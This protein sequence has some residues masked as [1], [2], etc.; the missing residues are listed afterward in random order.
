MVDDAGNEDAPPPSQTQRDP[1]PPPR[2]SL[3]PWLALLAPCC[4][5]GLS[6]FFM[7]RANA[8]RGPTGSPKPVDP[9]LSVQR[10]SARGA[11][12]AASTAPLA[13]GELT[14]P[15]FDEEGNGEQPRPGKRVVPQHFATVQQAAVG[16][17]STHSVDGLSRQIIAQARC[18]EPKAFVPLP[19]RPNLVVGEQ[20]FP[21]LEP[22]AR[23][24]LVRAL[25]AHPKVTM[26][27]NSA[28]RTLAQQYLV[29]RWAASKTCG[30]KLA[31]PPG[32]SN[33]EV[34]VAL[35]IAE[36]IKWRPA[37][38]AEE[39][40]WLGSADRV[41]FDFKGRSV[42][43]RRATDVLAF[44]KLWNRNHRAD[45]IAENGEYGPATEE[46]LKKAPS[47]GFPLGPICE[48]TGRPRRT[49]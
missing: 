25:D 4:V 36:G 15:V 6:I 35:D 7:V 29:W 19:K 39:F 34:G 20:V 21:Y 43:A 44:Q 16:S 45:P 47:S 14:F 42:A 3:V 18:I 11:G 24:H 2:R 12:S 1:L 23:E 40:R 10:P 33:H 5:I 37:L 22:R 48:K 27:I 46:R 32:E 31:T 38:E 26:T 49:P 28:L 8:G 9:R 17:C 13:Q 41:H 30:V